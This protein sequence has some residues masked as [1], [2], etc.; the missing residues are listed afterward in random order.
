VL[1]SETQNGNLRTCHWKSHYPIA[2][3]LVAIAV[4]NYSYYSN[5]VPLGSGDSL[6]VLN[7]V[8]PEDLTY[9]QSNTP[10]IISIIQLYDSLTITYP[11]FKEKYGHCQFGWG[12]GMEHQTM[13]YLVSFDYSLMA[14]ECAHQWFG[15]MVTCG[16]WEDIWLNE[17]FATYWQGMT[18]EHYDPSNWMGWKQSQ[19]DYIISQPDGSVLCTDTTDVG[20]IFDGRLTYSKGAYL[21][22][23]LR[24][25]VGDAAFFQA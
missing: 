1:V 17:G 13:T 18:V 15:D 3:Y 14:H 25:T 16:S 6:Q 20:R 23:M 12:G 5:Y 21:L 19:R 7:Y 24:W 9:A 22:H 8:Y 4:T 2:A 10:G 11:F